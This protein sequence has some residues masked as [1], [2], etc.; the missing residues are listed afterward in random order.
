MQELILNKFNYLDIPLNELPSRGYYYDGGAKIRGR[1]LNLRDIKFISLINSEN[2]TNIVNEILE[3]CFIF[4]NIKLS[5]LLLA[6]REYLAL[7][8]RANSF[9]ENNG[10]K[11]EIKKCSHC[12]RGFSKEIRIEEMEIQ[13]LTDPLIPLQLPDSGDTVKL[14]FPSVADLSIVDDDYEIQTMARMIDYVDDPIQF[15]LNLSAYDYAFLQDYINTYQIGFKFEIYCNC[16]NCNQPH[17]IRTMITDENIFPVL[18]IRDVYR[19]VLHCTKYTTYKIDDDISWPE[20]EIISD[21]VDEM[22]KKENEEMQKQQAAANAKAA[23]M[24]S[25]YSSSSYHGHR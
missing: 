13:Y 8:L 20:L 19:M 12:S 10:F 14:K 5:D 1:F 9:V 4:E 17:T 7:W 22:V 24:K 6:D 18:N 16:P 23:A 11:I 15:V 21:V 25:K 3:R 2:A